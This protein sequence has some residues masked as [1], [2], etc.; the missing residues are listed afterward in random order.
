MT[1]YYSDRDVLVTTSGVRM[2]GREFRTRDLER[3]WHTQGPRQWNRVA[4]RG[5]LGLA[6]ITPVVLGMLAVAVA[7]ALDLSL[8]TMVAVAGGG[9]L[10]GLGAIPLTDVLLDFVDRSHDRGTRS[11]EIWARVG[12]AEILLLRTGD[13]QRFGQIYRALQRALDQDSVPRR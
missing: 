4:G 10:L 3:V 8:T 13:R 2:G 7:L 6:M 5:F 9:I 11:R 1:T 12:N